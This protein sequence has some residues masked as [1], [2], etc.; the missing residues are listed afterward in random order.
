MTT[1]VG[2]RGVALL[3]VLWLIVVL[4][5]VA[6]AVAA[7]VRI[8]GDI[9]R[10]IRARAAA[11]YAAESGVIAA[12]VRLEELLRDAVTSAQLARVLPRL[13]A[14]LAELREQPLGDVALFQVAVTDLNARIDLNEADPAMLLGLL[15]QFVGAERAAALVDAL[16]DWKDA[17]DLR[18][19]NG[20][21]AQEYA[22]AGSPFRPPNRPL[23]RLDEMTRILGFSEALA[24]RLAPYVT[25]QSDGRVNLN[26]A[27][28]PVLA[29]LRGMGPAGARLLVAARERGEVFDSPVALWTG[30]RQLGISLGAADM[31]HVTTVARQVLVVSRGWERGNPL[32][33]EVQ[34]VFDVDGP[35]LT[36]RMWTERDL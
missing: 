32:T 31:A 24:D 15:Q 16:E 5:A 12:K 30:L 34:A 19:P 27:P 36:L 4:G 7:G 33:H 2:R 35:R 26:T 10:N 17:D 23:H 8:E 28:E 20:A 29:A 21:E 1:R 14:E 9:V 22:R 25:V 11:R 3:L 6:A 13:D 18:R